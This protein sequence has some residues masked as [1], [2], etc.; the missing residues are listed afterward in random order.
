MTLWRLEWLR[1]VRTRRLVV[2]IAVYVFFGLT[3]PLSARY[4]GEILNRVGGGIKVE[5]PAPTAKNVAF[6][7]ADVLDLPF[8]T[9]DHALAINVLDCVPDPRGLL[10]E[11]AR[12]VRGDVVLAT[13]YDWSA[14][15]TPFAA[16]LGGHSQRGDD[17]G[18]SEPAL[19]R[20]LADAGFRIVAERDRVPWR[21][22]VHARSAMEYAVHL[23]HVI[24]TQ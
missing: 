18:A 5:L 22:Y 21:L 2:I 8:R 17:A 11:C 10:A 6:V 9:A 4:L 23:V 24:S 14:N 7:C 3:G 1:L 12:V 20:A 19:R 15:A 16:W 13:P